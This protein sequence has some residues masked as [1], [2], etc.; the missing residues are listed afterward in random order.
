MTQMAEMTSH[1]PDEMLWQR[2]DAA[3]HV[4]LRR[5][6]NFIVFLDK[7]LE[8]DWENTPEHEKLL[9]AQ[10]V[11]PGKIQGRITCLEAVPIDHLSESIRRAFRS[12]LGESMC[13]ALDGDMKG[14]QSLLGKAE[15]FITARNHEHARQWYVWASVWATIAFVGATWAAASLYARMYTPPDDAKAD[16]LTAGMAGATGAL[17]SI[18]LRVGRAPLD[19]AAG[20]AIHRLEGAARIAVG[21]IGAIIVLCAI[22]SGLVLPQLR[23]RHG[24]ALACFVAGAS[25][26]LASGII[27]HV[28]TTLNKAAQKRSE[29]K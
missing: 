25:E 11:D 24:I 21:V 18:L 13:V 2:H 19:P 28:E 27:E 1:T 15:E 29:K 4:L 5:N 10:K 20:A 26:R 22:R 6:M 3:I 17:L 7:S 8:V 14:A 12:I 16:I 23:N 9:D